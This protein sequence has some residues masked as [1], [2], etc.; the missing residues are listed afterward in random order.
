[1]NGSGCGKSC[2]RSTCRSR[3]RTSCCTSLP[4]RPS[5]PSSRSWKSNVLGSERIRES[6]LRVLRRARERNHV[7]DVRHAGRILNRALEAEP[8]ARMRDRAVAAQIAIPA[9]VMLV[10]MHRIHAPVEIVET[11][12]T[13]R[14]A[15]DLADA[16]R[17]HVHCRD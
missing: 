16:R 9:V 15:D 1:M 7:A 3:P 4:S 17:E 10:E 5:S 11:L 8:E 12:L 6:E 14:A 2:T 13:L